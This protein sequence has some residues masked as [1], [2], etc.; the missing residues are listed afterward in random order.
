[1]LPSSGL[2]TDKSK[3]KC[4]SQ[5]ITYRVKGLCV[6]KGKLAHF[7]FFALLYLALSSLLLPVSS[8][9]FPCNLIIMA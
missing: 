1:M 9:P 6:E 8:F 5:A 2:G 3:C 4:K 7:F